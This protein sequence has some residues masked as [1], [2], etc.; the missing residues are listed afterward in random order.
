M[1]VDFSFRCMILSMLKELKYR[2]LA[3]GLPSKPAALA[4]EAIAYRALARASVGMCIR[5]SCPARSLAFLFRSS[6]R[7]SSL[8]ARSFSHWADRSHARLVVRALAHSP[9][10]SVVDQA[11]QAARCI[12]LDPLCS[13]GGPWSQPRKLTIQQLATIRV[14]ASCTSFS[15]L[16]HIAAEDPR[17]CLARH[18][19]LM[20]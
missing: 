2:I 16:A 6:R 4:E 17:G 10:R 11:I 15:T 1:L 20:R 5:L 19:L 8:S 18:L 14:V 9:F 13:R 3:E 7:C 12:R